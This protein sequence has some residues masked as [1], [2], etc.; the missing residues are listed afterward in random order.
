MIDV[1]QKKVVHYDSMQGYG[2]F[3]PFQQVCILLCDG[4]RTD[5]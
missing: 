3:G 1:L 5:I 4:D 2:G